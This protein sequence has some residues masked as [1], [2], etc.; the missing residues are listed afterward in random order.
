MMDHVADQEEDIKKSVAYT[1][2]SIL[3]EDLMFCFRC[4]YPY[5]ESVQSDELR[6]S[7][8]SKDCKFKETQVV[9]APCHHLQG[10][11]GYIMSYFRAK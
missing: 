6:E 5:F 7:G 2:R 8:F 11:P 10:L 3:E 9:L 4:D 1:T